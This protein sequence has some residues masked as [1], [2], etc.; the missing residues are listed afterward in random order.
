MRRRKTSQKTTL[1]RFVK[2][3]PD[4]VEGEIDPDA[5]QVVQQSKKEEADPKQEEIKKIK[6]YLKD[7]KNQTIELNRT[8]C[9]ICGRTLEVPE[10]I[11]RGIGPVCWKR[12]GYYLL[13]KHISNVFDPGLSAI[14]PDTYPK[15]ERYVDTITDWDCPNCGKDLHGGDVWHFKSENGWHLKGWVYPQWISIM[16]PDCKLSIPIEQ[17]G[18]HK[19]EQE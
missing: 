3:E 1:D 10:S 4:A 15:L 12:V 7:R 9:A 6:K 11:K 14:D 18:G 5:V 8:S 16:C 13:Y 17:L 2:L 19:I